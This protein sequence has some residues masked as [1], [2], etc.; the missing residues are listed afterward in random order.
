MN[1]ITQ[2]KFLLQSQQQIT[3]DQ[4]MSAYK[5][6]IHAISPASAWKTAELDFKLM[7]P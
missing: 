1:Q 4:C 7:S 2:F 5:L 3:P 6:A